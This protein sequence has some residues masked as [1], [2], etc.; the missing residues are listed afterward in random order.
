MESTQ[1][2][3]TQNKEKNSNFK[4]IPFEKRKK[5][6]VILFILPA[7]LI[8]CTFIIYP[9]IQTVYKSAFEFNGYEVGKFVGFE[10]Y[11]ATL[12]DPVFWHANSNTLKMLAVQLLVC[13]PF[14]FLLAVIINERSEKFRKYFKIAVFLPAVLNVAVISLMWKMMLQP[15]WGTLDV[16]LKSL[17]LEDYIVT[18]LAHEDYAIWIIGFV[19]LWQYIGFNMIYFYAGLRAIPSSYYE[20]ARVAGANFWQRTLHIS[21]PLTQEI[22]KFVLIISITGTMQIFTQIQLM[23]NGGPGDLTRSLIFQMYYKAFRVFDFGQ[24]GA[25]AVLF[26]IETFIMVLLVNRFVARDKIELT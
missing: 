22:I 13:G 4:S 20:A 23:T 21:I 2:S 25:V 19:V 1:T 15:D 18:W 5:I 3:N 24:A 8:F 7:L 14:S 6:T 12:N 11:K 16:I 10:H 17:G 9:L 26:A